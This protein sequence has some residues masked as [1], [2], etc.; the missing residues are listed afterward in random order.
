MKKSLS[1]YALY[2]LLSLVLIRV[3]GILARI[4]MARSITPYEYGLITLIVLTLPGFLQIITNFCFFDMLGHATEGKKYF[5]F[6]LIYGTVTTAVITLVVFLFREPIFSFLNIPSD[7]WLLYVLVFIGTLFTVTIIAD[8]SSM[9]RGMRNHTLN[10]SFS[11]APNILRVAFIFLAI[12]IFGITNFNQN[13]IIFA[14]PPFIVLI[15]V[16]IVKRKAILSSLQSISIPTKEMMIFGFSFFILNA[17]LSLS[18]HINSIVISHDLGVIWQG[19]FD[20]SLSIV[21][22]ISF[23]STAIYLVAAP[24]TT[25]EA[26]NSEILHR[27]GGFG[28]IGR[29]LFSMCILCVLIIYFYSHQIVTLLF[30]SRY[31]IAGDYLIILAIGYTVLFIQQYCAFLTISSE[32]DRVSKLMV[33]TVVSI[34]AFPFITHFMI[35]NFQFMGAYLATT[36]LIIIYT[37][38][39]LLF[40]KD[41]RPLKLL[42]FKLDRLVFS[43]AGTF[44]ILY[45]LQ[46]SLF[47]GLFVSTVS[48]FIFIVILG[49]V[50]K[51]IITEV[52][53]EEK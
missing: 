24:E 51:N 16:L 20:I 50:D 5:G 29:L 6:T 34:M 26:N 21:A 19:Y 18:Q 48:F 43:L 3:C 13:L 7:F 10:V 11:L 52:L 1:F 46:L 30:S 53:K 37:A 31:S 41:T 15:G 35:L 33:L 36:L 2:Y 8:I 4:L 49:Y 12:Y 22:V 17:W 27:K 39:S 45:F 40:I 14:L 42:V 44:L 47:A 9:L 32:G 28:D 38:F 25:A 23:L